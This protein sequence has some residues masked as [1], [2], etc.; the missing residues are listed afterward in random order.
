M[1][2]LII[3]LLI[4]SNS[5]FCQKNDDFEFIKGDEVQV[6]KSVQAGC[7]DHLQL[8]GKD[9]NYAYYFL[10][11]YN[12]IGNKDKFT[13][14]RFNLNCKEFKSFEI[15]MPKDFGESIINFIEIIDNELK[16][17]YS[18]ID[19]NSK[20]SNIYAVTIDKSN[21][22]LKMDKNILMKVNHSLY[23]NFETI[24]FN[25]VKSEDESHYL[26]NY[27]IYCENDYNVIYYGFASFDQD[28]N[29]LWRKDKLNPDENYYNIPNAFYIS[30][31]GTVFI[32]YS[33]YFG[34]MYSK[35]Y[36]KMYKPFQANSFTY[37]LPNYKI[38]LMKYTENDEIKFKFEIKNKFINKINFDILSDDSIM[39]YGFV[40]ELNYVSSVG[41]FSYL[42]TKN[43][44]EEIYPE[45]KKFKPEFISK[46]CTD[47]NIDEFN[48]NIRKLKEFE[49]C[50]YLFKQI[51]KKPDGSYIKIAEQCYDMFSTFIIKND[52]II[53][54]IDKNGDI[55]NELK[56]PKSQVYS[57]SVGPLSGFLYKYSNDTLQL[58]YNDIN[59]K[60]AEKMITKVK[61][62]NNIKIS[63]NYQITQETIPIYDIIESNAC[64]DASL[65]LDENAWFMCGL[66]VN[67]F[68][69]LP[70]VLILK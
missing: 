4:I 36:F 28:L 5:V 45:F 41:H 69:A 26:I 6:G 18:T 30:N 17:F 24:A 52:L 49:P 33:C 51:I 42:I 55:Q 31:N 7:P 25:L 13:L 67:G 12:F 22:Q 57:Q 70:L 53:T 21:M 8:I 50:N 35:E 32:D 10:A 65:Q 39:C 38:I 43:S 59:K 47:D 60:V 20:T 62:L 58:I 68:K 1:K 40:S 37:K 48:K 61:V 14:Y 46:G 64:I 15:Q 11:C 3:A 19:K 63:N 27:T 34:N 44:E 9:E 54:Y 56:I 23:K 16:I 2:K 66:N 29:L